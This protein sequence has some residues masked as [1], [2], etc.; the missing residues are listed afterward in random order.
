M[1]LE[2]YGFTKRIWIL[3]L[4]AI[5]VHL[6]FHLIAPDQP[7]IGPHK[8]RQADTLFS[9]Y[10]YCVENTEF[11]KPRILHRE[12]TNGVA[13]GEFPVYNYLMSIP[14]KVTGIWSATFLR[15]ITFVFYVL[16]FFLLG[17]A[18]LNAWGKV[19]WEWLTLFWFFTPLW[20]VYGPMP[21][22]D[23][24]TLA[25]F[26]FTW[27]WSEKRKAT[28]SNVL[29][30]LLLVLVFLIR[31]F[32]YPM[33]LLVRPNLK[34]LILLTG[35]CG[36]GYLIWFKW[37]V[38]SVTEIEYYA[39]SN[40]SLIELVRNFWSVGHAFIEQTLYHHVNYIGL[41]LLISA[42]SKQCRLFICWAFAWAFILGVKADHFVNH[43][44]YMIAAGFFALLL[45]MKSDFFANKSK[46]SKIIFAAV[47]IAICLGNVQ[48]HYLREKDWIVDAG[49]KVNEQTQFS[50]KIAMYGGTKIV[51]L[52]AALRTGW[53]LPYEDFK[54][55][56]YC[57]AGAVWAWHV[58][59]GMKVSDLVKCVSWKE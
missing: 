59:E 56:E 47:Y 11:L 13:V 57:P 54:N 22:P 51:Y 40:K 30:D 35:L 55:G 27:I 31:P 2:K 50:E 29:Q 21:I 3:V 19:R 26:L 9:S 58:D 23:G 7:L 1:L 17:I 49:A 34:R 53:L 14:C 20:F 25:L 12:G 36:V 5:T 6:I 32:F 28:A 39:I 37:W 8:I 42:I 18:L 45:M 44:Y 10:S 41:L 46:K 24:F 38:P 15:G 16:N 48:H 4:T 52:Y 33:F 43:P